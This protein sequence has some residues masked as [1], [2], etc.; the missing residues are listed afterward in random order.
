V[1]RARHQLLLLFG[2][3]VCQAAWATQ[4]LA[5]KRWKTYQ[6]DL[7]RSVVE[8]S[9]PDGESH[10]FPLLP[11]PAR[12]DSE[13]KGAFD[14]AGIGPVLLER[15]WDY[16]KSRLVAVQGNLHAHIGLRHSEAP[17]AEP[18]DLRR[19]VE[20]SARLW[21]EMQFLKSGR[22][23]PTVTNEPVRFED[24]IVGGR[25][26]FLVRFRMSSPRYVVPVA[27]HV[28]LEISCRTGGFFDDQW[29]ADAKH[30]AEKIV[31]SIRVADEE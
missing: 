19:A 14:Q 23:R 12:I 6:V 15:S 17:L 31:G 10:E 30:A 22:P 24:A 28:Y 3:A 29:E 16:R 27:E 8:F 20:E 18:S 9:I 2:L 1:R 26:G 13:A 4:F 5:D 21:E 11:I 7:G 25:A